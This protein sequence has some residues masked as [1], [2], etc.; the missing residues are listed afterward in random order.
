MPLTRHPHARLTLGAALLFSLVSVVA[1]GSAEE[2]RAKVITPT[3]DCR[4]GLCRQTVTRVPL[5][6]LPRPNSSIWKER[7]ID[8]EV[9][10]PVAPALSPLFVFAREGVDEADADGTK[11]WYKVGPTDSAPSGW[12]Q[13]R[14][15]IEWHNTLILSYTPP[16]IDDEARSRVLGFRDHEDLRSVVAAEDRKSRAEDLLE[17]VTRFENDA[18]GAQQEVRAA[19]VVSAEPKGVF[20]DIKDT[21]YMWP[22]LSWSEPDAIDSDERYL[23]FVQ[24]MPECRADDIETAEVVGTAAGRESPLVLA[25]SRRAAGP[26]TNREMR[27]NATIGNAP[28]RNVDVLFVVDTTASMQPY[29]DAVRDGIRSAAARIED[30]AG[31]GEAVRFGI[32]GFEDDFAELDHIAKDYFPAGFVD[33]RTFIET[34][35]SS[36]KAETWGDH[37]V[38]ERLFEGVKA[39]IEANWSEDAL[40]FMVVVT[41]APG[42]PQ[43]AGVN[44]S[45]KRPDENFVRLM[46]DDAT[47]YERLAT[48]SVGDAERLGKMARDANVQS[49]ALHIK[50][51]RTPEMD[52]LAGA[53][54]EAMIQN[55][56]TDAGYLPVTGGEGSAKDFADAIG[57]FTS[58]ITV[59]LGAASLE[60]VELAA[61]VMKA[62]DE[63]LPT[64]GDLAAEAR[65]TGV[66]LVKAAMMDYLGNSDSVECDYRAWT[67]DR[68]LTDDA[69]RSLNVNTLLVRDELDTLYRTL[70]MVRD[71]LAAGELSG[72]EFIDSLK[73]ISTG[74]MLD[75]DT[76]E[77]ARSGSLARAGLLPSWLD[78]LPYRSDISQLSGQDIAEMTGA[79]RTQLEINVSQKLAY[80]EGIMEDRERWFPLS[81]RDRD[82]EL[83]WVTPLP[84]E[85][86]P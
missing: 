13:A 62:A 79:D 47:A 83:K 29:I 73:S 33:A 43:S 55:D 85:E 32:V 78:S 49:F 44:A 61:A 81:D 22:I 28:I 68:D 52:D 59:G 72:E 80:Y 39:G 65:D 37:L 20:T 2:H 35:G 86:L 66:A 15:V 64:N 36:V 26:L 77:R 21:F 14:D 76:I 42:I 41:D 18:D 71:A 24:L 23:E 84:V 53:Q 11:G 5:K 50:P 46:A 60:E 12:M 6:V 27:D 34:V 45:A 63:S 8:G 70:T 57:T 56:G 40:R 48:V 19:G 38:P 3:I 17:A 69:V 58:A 30:K 16:G 7:A 25:G 54:L 1:S 67:S 31:D 75:P 74:T 10:V 4:E 51:G 9:V 82:N